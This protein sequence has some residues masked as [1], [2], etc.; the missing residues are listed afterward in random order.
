MMSRW[1]AQRI[2][3]HISRAARQRRRFTSSPSY[4]PYEYPTRTSAPIIT[5]TLSSSATSA[6][7]SESQSQ[8]ARPSNNFD[9]APSTLS[10]TERSQ[11]LESQKNASEQLPLPPSQNKRRSHCWWSFWP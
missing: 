2:L 1:S 4:S 8:K 3:P 6:A 10:P 9:D 5:K 11:I 7:V